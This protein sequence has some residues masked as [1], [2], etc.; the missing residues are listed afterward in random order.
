LVGKDGFK[1]TSAQIAHDPADERIDVI[2]DINSLIVWRAAADGTPLQ[3]CGIS[4]VLPEGAAHDSEL[5]LEA[6]HPEDREKVRPVWRQAIRSGTVFQ[7]F[8]R[9]RQPDDS[10]R[11]SYGCGVP[12]IDDDGSVR[13]WLGTIADIDDKI[14]AQ[15]ALAYSE[16]RLKSAQASTRIGVWEF[17]VSTSKIWLSDTAAEILGHLSKRPISEAEAWSLIHPDDRALLR[18]RIDTAYSGAGDG[19]WESEFRL[20][21]A[22]TGTSL[23]VVCSAQA[24]L[25]DAGIPVRVLG[26]IQDITAWRDHQAACPR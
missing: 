18:Q 5:W 21:G 26:T 7:S 13:E 2:A 6:L 24:R 9:L 19:R 11:W 3:P 25:D 12:L 17:D 4:E 16:E 1:L 23:W 15:Q 14:K 20:S 8:Y 10:F 22:A